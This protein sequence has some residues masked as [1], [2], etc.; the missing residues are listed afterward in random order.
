MQFCI[1]TPVFDGCLP[2]LKLLFKELKGQTYT[3]W[4]WTL[5]S[6]GYSAKMCR[7]VRKNNRA[8]ARVRLTSRIRQL[9]QPRI[10]YVYLPYEE[11]PDA[12]GLLENISKRRDH[13]IKIVQGDYICMID[14]DAKL[15]DR[16]MFTILNTELE[17]N[18]QSLCIYKIMH[19]LGVLPKFPIRYARIDQLNFCVKARLAK[20]VGY[21]TTLNPAAQGNDYWYFDRV[22]RATGGEYLFIDKIFGQHNGNNRYVNILQQL[23][24]QASTAN[25]QSPS[26]SRRLWPFLAW[27][28]FRR[29]AARQFIKKHPYFPHENRL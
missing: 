13:C 27:P 24:R 25:P 21:P 15:L 20:E 9:P 2:S 18:P 8:L 29:Q 23:S 19:K 17:R 10:D 11:T 16:D 28:F 5:C 7:F 12:H 1:I 26:Q 6:N 22:C 14:A 4:T 3:D